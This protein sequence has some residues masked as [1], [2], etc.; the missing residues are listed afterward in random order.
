MR[1]ALGLARALGLYPPPMKLISRNDELA[2]ACAKLGQAPF[3]A[4]DTEFMREQTFW[5]RLCLVQLAA[6]GTEVLIDGLAPGL[7]LTPLFELMVNEQ[8]L[9]VFHSARQDI[10]IVHHLA[11]VIPHPIFDT[12]VAAMVC[13][14]GEAVSYVNLVKQVTHHD[15]DKTSRFTDWARRPLSQKQLTYALGDVVHLRDIYRHL[16]AELEREGRAGW[17]D[18]EMATLTEPSTYEANPEQAW[19]RLN[20]PA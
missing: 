12:Q 5:P 17:L 8:A 3:V 4:V 10:E 18:E 6:N 14:F 2:E 15:L 19:K 11:G 13:G 16:K 7:D 1:S 20:L 9:K